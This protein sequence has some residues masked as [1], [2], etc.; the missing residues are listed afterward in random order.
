MHKAMAHRAMAHRAVALALVAGGG[1]WAATPAVAGSP[2]RDTLSGWGPFK[3]QMSSVEASA[4]ANLHPGGLYGTMS[5]RTL[6]G[7]VPHLA[8][9]HFDEVTRSLAR[10]A[11]VPETKVQTKS[12]AECLGNKFQPVVGR[13]TATYGAPDSQSSRFIREAVAHDPAPPA[14]SRPPAP[15]VPV[16]ASTV[17]TPPSLTPSLTPAS[18]TPALVAVAKPSVAPAPQLGAHVMRYEYR[19]VNGGAIDVEGRYEIAGTSAS[20]NCSWTVTYRAPTLAAL[21]R[22]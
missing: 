10:I 21:Q 20:R 15:V 18:P 4:I 5:Y 19:F 2:L 22:Y 8:K 16:A 17:A 6:V 13:I 7:G 1:L 9:L 12:R 11:L 14:A 3:F